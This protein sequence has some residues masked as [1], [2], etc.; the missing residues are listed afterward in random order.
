MKYLTILRHA[1]AD[2]PDDYHRDFDRPLTKRGIKDAEQVARLIAKLEPAVDWVISSPSVRTRET[3]EH[4]LPTLGLGQQVH[5]EDAV[6]AAT[7]EALLG[8]LNAAP[9]EASHILLVGHNPGME[10]LV[11][12]LAAGTPARLSC[13]LATAAF[14]HLEIEIVYWNQIRWGSGRLLNLVRPK[15]LRA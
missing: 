11:S 12:G 9:P 7:A 1:K 5:W 4:V 8:A 13:T 10:E 15:L 3:T 2:R 6:Y 14:A